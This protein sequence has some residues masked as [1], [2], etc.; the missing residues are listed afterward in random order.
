MR[1]RGA[2][3]NPTNRFEPL[4]YC[5]DPGA[6]G[7]DP[8]EG[9]TR[10]PRTRL[11]RDPSRS[12]VAT[13]ASPDVGFDASVNPYRGCEHGCIYCYARPTHEYLGLSAGLDFETRIL[14]KEG[15]PE[16]LR[17]RLSS[18]AWR[19]QVLALSGVTDPYQPAERALEITRGCLRVLAGFRNP[20]GVITK[21][22]LVT[23]DA[24]LLGELA[25]HGAASVA[26]S[27]TTLDVDL[28]HRMEPRASRPSKRLAAI[29]ALAEAGVP[30]GVM[31]A[32]VVPG[33]TDHEIPRI[34]AAAAS[35]GA[36]FAG[37]VLLRLPHGVGP[38]FSDWLERHYPERREK[39]LSRVRALRGGRLYDARFG[40]RQTGEGLF[41]REIESLFALGCR[42]AGLARRGPALSVAAFRRPSEARAQLDLFA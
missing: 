12:I 16:L 30:V 24:D 17:R 19:P 10:D 15:A 25:R 9:V 8:G 41:A 40:L 33:L 2:K 36:G 11:L 23:R 13:N 31:V 38:L 26:V 22:W 1:A 42:R 3:D 7:G 28:Q 6:A 5:E 39:V 18:P 21:S 37:K 27:I 32:P 35:A 34:L 20:V 4:R 14:V 29:E